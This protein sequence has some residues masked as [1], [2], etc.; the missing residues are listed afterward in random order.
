MRMSTKEFQNYGFRASM[1][2][3]IRDPFKCISEAATWA[4]GEVLAWIAGWETLPHNFLGGCYHC[5][6]W[7]P[8]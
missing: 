1:P 8:V 6:N 5:E 7:R 4:H 3:E 2:L